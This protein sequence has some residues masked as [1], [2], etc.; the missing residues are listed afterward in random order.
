[1]QETRRT[2]GRLKTEGFAL[3]LENGSVR[4]EGSLEN[5]YTRQNTDRAARY[6][7]MNP[8]KSTTRMFRIEVINSVFLIADY[9]KE[10][11]I[12]DFVL[13][14]KLGGIC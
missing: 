12:H 11:P 2:D 4:R 8:E 1:M 3:E 7:P 10:F 6:E 5:I 14:R 9:V 13:T